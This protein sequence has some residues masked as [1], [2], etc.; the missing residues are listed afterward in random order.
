MITI[1]KAT[2]AQALEM[3][4]RMRLDDQ[5]EVWASSGTTPLEALMRS[6][7][8]PGEHWAALDDGK[9][10]AMFGI[11]QRSLLG[12]KDVGVP[13]MLGGDGLENN[14]KVLLRLSRDFIKEASRQFEV[15]C[16]Y[17]DARY[18]AAI[19]WLEWLGFTM[20]RAKP[21][22]FEGLPFHRFELRR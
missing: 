9:V 3:A 4:P 6:I 14:T 2:Q 15:L 8:S 5:L 18:T 21:Y 19:R 7:N 11:S 16:N 1:E 22:G 12:A 20:E 10:V 17:V 13:W